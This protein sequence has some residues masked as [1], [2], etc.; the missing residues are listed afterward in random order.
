MAKAAAKKAVRPFLNEKEF[1]QFSRALRGAFTEP[2][3]CD[4]CHGNGTV[5]VPG[6]GHQPCVVCNG[7]GETP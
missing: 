7:T 3:D 1:L 5:S 4:T 6:A 2:I